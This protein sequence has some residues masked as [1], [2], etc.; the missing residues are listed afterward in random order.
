MKIKN[1]LFS[2]GM[3]FFALFQLHA[4]IISAQSQMKKMYLNN[5]VVDVSTTNPTASPIGLPPGTFSGISANGIYG[6]DGNLLFYM[7]GTKIY[8]KAVDYLDDVATATTDLVFP[9]MTV[10]PVPGACGKFYV[11]YSVDGAGH[12]HKSGG[13]DENE[14]SAESSS[15]RMHSIDQHIHYLEYDVYL[16]NGNGGIVPGKKDLLISSGIGYSGQSF[17]VGK[18]RNNTHRFLY[19]VNNGTVKRFTINSSGL[20]NAITLYSGTD[21]AS[22]QTFQ[23]ELSHNELMLAWGKNSNGWSSSNID[24]SILHLDANGALNTTLGVNGISQYNLHSNDQ[25][26]ITGVEFTPDNNFLYYTA[27]I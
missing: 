16:N 21:L 26:K 3:L 17:A 2:R 19:V 4:Q 15:N 20:T 18:L 9:E 12:Q 10:V 5:V 11:I 8:N 7:N 6:P 14:D 27:E 13:N 23:A 24:I 1:L 22:F 25:T